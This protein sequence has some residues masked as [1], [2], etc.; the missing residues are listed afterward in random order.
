MGLG[1]QRREC[2][3]TLHWLAKTERRLIGK[4]VLVTDA[5]EEML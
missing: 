3:R 4:L 2:I 5:G 1:E